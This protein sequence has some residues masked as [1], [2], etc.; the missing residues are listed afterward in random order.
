VQDEIKT[1]EVKTR[2]NNFSVF[3]ILKIYLKTEWLIPLQCE[4]PHVPDLVLRKIIPETLS[5]AL[6][7]NIDY[8]WISKNLR[9]KFPG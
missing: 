3:I 4:N 7:L 5:S 9:E 2:D 6:V 1:I 8:I